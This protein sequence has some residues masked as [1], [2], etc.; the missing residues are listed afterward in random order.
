MHSL[1]TMETWSQHGN[2]TSQQPSVW[3]SCIKG[4]FHEATDYN[5]IG[6]RCIQIGRWVQQTCRH[7]PM[8]ICFTLVDDQ[9]CY[10]IIGRQDKLS[11]GA[12]TTVQ[13]G[14][15]LKHKT[16][17]KFSQKKN[18]WPKIGQKDE[19]ILVGWPIKLVM[20]INSLR[21][22]TVFSLWFHPLVEP[23]LKSAFLLF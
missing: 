12:K 14:G 22:L 8:Y 19:R 13:C 21:S 7:R 23:A 3:E 17:V 11:F 4:R 10:F 15:Q 18:C 20:P 5:E 1:V 16:A 2:V 9:T 6:H